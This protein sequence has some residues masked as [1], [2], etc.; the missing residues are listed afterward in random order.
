[1]LNDEKTIIYLAVEEVQT[2]ELFR[3]YQAIWEWIFKEP[4]RAN[5]VILHFDHD[6]N[7]RLAEKPMFSSTTFEIKI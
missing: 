6:G 3:K 2:F 5:K 1:M 7:L 4:I